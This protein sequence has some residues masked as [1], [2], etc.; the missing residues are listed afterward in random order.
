[1]LANELTGAT[2]SS[3]ELLEVA[4]QLEGHP[5]NVAP[6][7][8]EA[9]LWRRTLMDAS[10]EVT[11][12]DA[13]ASVYVPNEPLLTTASRQA[14]PTE[15]AYHQA[16]T[17]SSVANT[18]VAALATQNWDVALPLLEQDQFHEQY[19]AKL[20]PALQTVRDHAHALG[21]TGTYLS[22]AGPTVITLGDYGQLATLQAQLSQD[23]TLTGQL[24]LLPMDA[25]GV[26]VQKS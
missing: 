26:K 23:T 5:D 15:L 19:R 11:V 9:W 2:R 18:L 13:F 8:L 4:T 24:F 16:V 3:A 25:T 12:T 21:L 22:G 7:L 20:V 6:A 17:G 1:M 10:A 14:L